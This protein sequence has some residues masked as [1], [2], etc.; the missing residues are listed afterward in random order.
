MRAAQDAPT[1]GLPLC[2]SRGKSI[3]EY[4]LRDV[5]KPRAA[6]SLSGDQLVVLFGVVI[7]QNAAVDDR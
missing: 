6:L 4:A 7:E 1:F 2:E 3:V 5:A